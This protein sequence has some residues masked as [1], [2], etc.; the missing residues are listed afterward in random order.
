MKRRAWWFIVLGILVV[1]LAHQPVSAQV[2]SARCPTE[3]SCTVSLDTLPT[4][5]QHPDITTLFD[6]TSVDA[7]HAQCNPLGGFVGTAT[8]TPGMLPEPICDFNFR[9]KCFFGGTLGF[10]WVISHWC[11]VDGGDGLPVELMDFA[12][13]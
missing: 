8:W 7:Q 3:G 6:S 4:C 9:R 1:P 5:G 11:R 12:V 13:E 10:T 2:C